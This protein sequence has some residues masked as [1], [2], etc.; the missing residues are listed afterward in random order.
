MKDQPD[1]LASQT[2]IKM[3]IYLFYF[4]INNIIL[5]PIFYFWLHLHSYGYMKREIQK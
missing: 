4:N 1:S 5:Y 3:L 2:A